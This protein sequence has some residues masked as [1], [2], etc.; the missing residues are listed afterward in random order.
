MDDIQFLKH[1]LKAMEMSGFLMVRSEFQ[2]IIWKEFLD[3]NAS[4]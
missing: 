4:V 2:S 3:S 1:H